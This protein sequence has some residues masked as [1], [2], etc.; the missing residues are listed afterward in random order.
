MRHGLVRIFSAAAF[1]AVIHLW[2]P[3]VNAQDESSETITESADPGSEVDEIAAE[4]ETKSVKSEEPAV[5]TSTAPTEQKLEDFSGLGT[6]AP[7]EEIS[8]IQR[9]FQPK[10]GRFQFFGGL[11]NVVNDPWFMG[12]GLD[13]RLAYHLTEAWGIE[14]GGNTLSNSERQSVKDLASEH[15]VKTDSLVT[16]KGYYGAALVWTPIYGKMGM[17]NRRIIPF[18]M[19]FQLGGGQT[20][21]ENGSGGSTIHFGTGQIFALSK[22]M[23]FR[24]D[25]SWNTYSATPNGTGKSSQNFNNLLLT[26]GA[27]FFFP[28]AKYR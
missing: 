27:S 23:G 8:V 25:F 1:L 2:V 3:A 22:G 4:I 11:T 9:R 14:I 21:I 13:A 12:I 7:F 24:W 20:Q 5:N 10:S 16:S 18:D 28:E 26:F 6:L 15:A 17:F 19:Y